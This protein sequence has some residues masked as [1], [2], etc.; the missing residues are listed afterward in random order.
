MRS[1]RLF[2]LLFW[3]QC[4]FLT[5]AQRGWVHPDSPEP[6]P[7]EPQA[8]PP[9]ENPGHPGEGTSGG[10]SS[11]GA[12]PPTEAGGPGATSQGENP[13]VSSNDDE[14]DIEE[15]GEKLEDL[16]DD[17]SSLVSIITSTSTSTSTSTD[18]SGSLFTTTVY[19]TKTTQR[20]LPFAV[21]G[22]A[23]AQ[24]AYATC[25]SAQPSASGNF[26]SLPRTQQASCLCNASPNINFNQEIRDCYNW[27]HAQNGTNNATQLESYASAIAN[28]TSLC[29]PTGGLSP[30]PTPV[31]SATAPSPLAPTGGS[32]GGWAS[33]SQRYLLLTMFWIASIS[34]LS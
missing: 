22:C 29:T 10:G 27:A 17:I 28:A 26:T 14:V 13:D 3:L 15:I 7:A 9:V 1:Y 23:S 11:G 19:A 4:I 18:D 8:E 30:T 24:A 32:A 31:P 20:P 2:I 33:A 12:R 21:S 16:I 6:K 34:A 5:H 25:Y